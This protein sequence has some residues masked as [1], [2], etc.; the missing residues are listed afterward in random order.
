MIGLELMEG[1][2]DENAGCSDSLATGWS[3]AY[4]RE[5]GVV[6]TD[7]PLTL[8][9]EHDVSALNSLPSQVVM[10]CPSS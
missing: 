7:I 1:I 3:D 8:T 5:K 10:P 4:E 2:K 6:F 9:L